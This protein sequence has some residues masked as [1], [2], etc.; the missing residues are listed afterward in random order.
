MST[1]SNA[2]HRDPRVTASFPNLGS[3]REAMSALE[4][5]GVDAARIELAGSATRL[6]DAGRARDREE[7]AMHYAGSRIGL[8]LGIGG[9]LG[10]IV[11]FAVALAAGRGG[12]S[13]IVGGAIAGIVLGAFLGG[14]RS[15][16]ADP[17][18]ELTF[19]EIGNRPVTVEVTG[20]ADLRSRA[21]GVL[22]TREPLALTTTDTD[23]GR[24]TA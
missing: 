3:A 17:D 10:L 11:G 4:R 9:A 1:P 7:R 20:D 8:G 16:D 13:V 12:V 2:K 15:L 23:D 18:W 19:A 21:F 24:R 6:A 22:R 14:M 5:A